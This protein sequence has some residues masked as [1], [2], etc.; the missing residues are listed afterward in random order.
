LIEGLN[1][2]DINGVLQILG[3]SL[4]ARSAARG[5]NQKLPPGVITSISNEMVEEE[6]AIEEGNSIELSTVQ[7]PVSSSASNNHAE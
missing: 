1:R 2:V 7:S 4:V 3:T 6:R 5:S